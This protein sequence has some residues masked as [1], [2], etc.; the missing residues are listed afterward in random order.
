MG[1]GKDGSASL[2]A[3]MEDYIAK[4]ARGEIAVSRFFTPGERRAAERI[5]LSSGAREQAFFWGGYT[6]AE[7]EC[8]FLLPRF[9]LDLPDLL[10]REN[11]DPMKRIT[12][13]ESTGVCAVRVRGSGFCKLSHR[14]YLG[15]ALG[16][17]IE[18][19]AVGD[20]AVQNDCEA[21]VFCTESMARF[22]L[23]T[24]KKVANDAVRCT[25]YTLDAS[26]TDGRKYKPI[27]DTVASA[28]LDCVVAALTNQSRE[29]AQSAIRTGLVEVDFEV[30]ERADKALTP[31]VT[32]SVRGYGRY[33]LRTFDGETKKGRLRMRA[34]QL[35]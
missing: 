29:D 33:I 15:S 8:L 35:V 18:R 28:R 16:L 5:L 9:Y 4:A 13:G 31:P 10:P 12:D 26:F 22:L 7:R 2:Q 20:I 32:I 25:L 17:G 14:D 19:D 34:D 11:E 3:R 23:E 6:D 21:V 24:L 1:R 30:E 27:T